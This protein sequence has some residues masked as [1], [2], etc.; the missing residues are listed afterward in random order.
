MVSEFTRRFQ[1]GLRSELAKRVKNYRVYS[2]EGWL[3]IRGEKVIHVDIMMESGR[4]LVLV[5]IE[6][7]RQ[8][9][10]NNI[11]KIPFWLKHDPVDKEVVVI[12]MFSPFYDKHKVKKGISEELG[13]LIMEKF[14]GKVQYKSIPFCPESSFEQFEEVYQNPIEN[15]DTMNTLVKKTAEKVSQLLKTH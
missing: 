7:H 10:S 6:S 15:E 11:A 5:E 14:E 13:K 8:D 1:N 4:R 3:K 2:R 12:Q 9:P